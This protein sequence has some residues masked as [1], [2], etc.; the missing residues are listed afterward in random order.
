MRLLLTGATG[1][2]GQAL[3]AAAPAD[4]HLV[5]LDRAALDLAEGDA[6]ARAIVDHAPT[7]VVNA[8]AYTAVDRAESEPDLAHAVNAVAP[9]LLAAAA[10][11]AGAAFVHVSTDFVFDGTLGRPYRPDDAANP[12]SVYGRTKWEGEEAVR[13]AHPSPLI[14]RTAWVHA[15]GGR[16]FVATMLRLMAERAEIGVVADQ[17]GTPT[18]A[19]GLARALLE[20]A[21]A[22]V[23]GTHHWT[24]AGV[25]SWYDFAVAIREEALSLGLLARAAVVRPIATA[26]YPTPARRPAY[27]ILDKA[28][29]WAVTGPPAHW[30]EGLRACLEA[31]WR[32]R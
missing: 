12:L 27:G 3:A 29:A 16:N 8:A 22:G 9:G 6:I 15:A 25:A 26:D 18:H 31:P 28:S 32:D 17:L 14:V 21:Q 13:A 20:L 10:A 24:D 5:A 1:Q 11:R 23:T 2:L 30:R 4:A 7:L 19:D